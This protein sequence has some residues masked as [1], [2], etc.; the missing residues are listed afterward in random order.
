MHLKVS[1]ALNVLE[2]EATEALIFPLELRREELS[3]KEGGKM[4][5]QRQ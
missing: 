3:I 5:V 4:H 1:E 2:I